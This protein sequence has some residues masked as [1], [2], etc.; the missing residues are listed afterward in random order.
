M[1]GMMNFH[2]SVIHMKAS[3]AMQ[4]PEHL[5]PLKLQCLYRI[6]SNASRAAARERYLWIKCYDRCLV[7]SYDEI[8]GHP[9]SHNLKPC[10]VQWR[11][12]NIFP[13]NWQWPGKLNNW[14]IT[15]QIRQQSFKDS[16]KNQISANSNLLN[17][18]F[19]IF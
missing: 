8:G 18:L 11:R 16:T 3:M 10:H 4:L 19:F 6:R 12:Y 15:S 2:T 1:H 17:R 7:A 5:V 9:L 14:K 13:W